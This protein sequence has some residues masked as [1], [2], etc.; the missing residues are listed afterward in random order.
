MI[1]FTGRNPKEDFHVLTFKVDPDNSK[2]AIEYVNKRLSELYSYVKNPPSV[3]S[4][5]MDFKYRFWNER[6]VN[7]LLIWSAFFCVLISCLGFFGLSSFIA[8]SKSKEIGIRKVN[9]ATVSNIVFSLTG[10]FFKLVLISSIIAC[11][12]A[13]YFMSRWFENFTFRIVIEPWI[14]FIG[15]IIAL[16]ITGLTVSYHSIKAAMADPVKA[17]RYE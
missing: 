13:Y 9:G 1:H 11:P 7:N 6:L 8:E 12:I 16:I 14:F 5:E 3:S 10:E 2:E 17:L 15:I 4:L